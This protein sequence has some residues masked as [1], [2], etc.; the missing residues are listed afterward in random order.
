M[1]LREDLLTPIAGGNPSGENL[2][3]A[4][5]YDKIKEA[6]RE[7]DDA[8]QGEWQ[9]ERK[10]ADF[11]QVIKLAGDAIAS[12]SK[13]IQLAAWLTEALLRKESFGGLLQGLQLIKGLIDNFWDTMY[14]EIEDG[15]AE[16]RAAPL[17]WV[18]SRLDEP[19]R[20]APLVKSGYGYFKYKESRTVGSEE[21]AAASDSKRE[22]RETAVS[23]GKITVEEFD[24]AFKLTP[25]KSYEAWVAELDSS[26]E[27]LAELNDL[28]NEKFGDFAPS[29]SKLQSGLEE[30]RHTAN[31]L[32]QKKLEA[33][34]RVAAPAAEE[35][36]EEDAAEETSEESTSARP[37]RTAKRKVVGL[38]PADMEDAVARLDAVAKFLRV[39]DPFNPA[40]YL[41]LRGFRWG[42]LRAYGETPD[43][44]A[45]LPPDSEIR[46]QLKRLSLDANWAELLEL[47]E[48]CMATPAGRAWLDLQRYVVKACDNFGYYAIAHAIRS[49]LRTLLAD[50][51]AMT[52]WTLM[53]DTPTANAET[54]AWIGEFNT[55]PAAAAAAVEEPPPMIM[56]QRQEPEG[57][58]EEQE[59]DIYALAMQSARSGRPKEGIELLAQDIPRQQSGRSRFQRKLQLAQLCISANY[60][61]L[62]QPILEELA[63]EIDEHKLEQWESSDTVAHPLAL[64]YRCM[65]KSDGDGKQKLYA[66]I[67][68]LDP[69][70]ALSFSR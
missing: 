65:N 3:Y 40:A 27:L 67:C 63:G 1:P 10:T 53:D 18:G 30:V 22:A 24:N 23:E 44:T 16:L 6:R 15:D 55:P 4:P 66:R 48:T 20:K 37:A 56:M 33:E 14:P 61:A 11:N 36:V 50:Y 5:V 8:P 28:C 59:P 25:T 13:D 43:P 60:E 70:Q 17:D 54:I 31:S 12:K 9:R 26:S 2:R 47:A 57:E 34:G 41:L 62:A 68:R 35:A 29:F 58:G 52:Q 32:L 46:Q 51:P 69:M 49:E 42:E 7:D 21:D 39:S 45:L 64:L 38:E 19:L